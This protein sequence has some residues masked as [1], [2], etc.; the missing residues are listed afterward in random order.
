MMEK[1]GQHILVV[2]KLLKQ[3]KSKQAVKEEGS[4]DTNCLIVIYELQIYQRA[5][6]HRREKVVFARRKI[7]RS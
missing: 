4:V 6:N 1:K 7:E 5:R 3:K 2:K